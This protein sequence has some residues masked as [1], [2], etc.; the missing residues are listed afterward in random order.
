MPPNLWNDKGRN[1]F[2][3]E[4]RALI[5]DAC[6]MLGKCNADAKPA[7][8]LAKTPEE[9]RFDIPA[10]IDRPNHQKEALTYLIVLLLNDANIYLSPA[11]FARDYFDAKA[12]LPL[13]NS[14]NDIGGA[15]EYPAH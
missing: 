7:E 3:D 13:E 6:A 8:I 14:V 1:L 10:L 5:R 9:L 15:Q 2:P 12:A 11:D 4:L